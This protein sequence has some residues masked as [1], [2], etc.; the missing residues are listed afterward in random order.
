MIDQIGQSTAR[1]NREQGFLPSQKM[2]Q[3]KMSQIRD[4]LLKI[5]HILPISHNI[6]S[7]LGSGSVPKVTDRTSVAEP[8]SFLTA[9]APRSYKSEF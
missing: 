7:T 5:R 3:I 9:P 2:S 6:L 4:W 1:G 8:K